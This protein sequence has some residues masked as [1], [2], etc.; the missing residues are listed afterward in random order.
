M[1]GKTSRPHRQR[2]PIAIERTDLSH[3]GRTL[4]ERNGTLIARAVYGGDSEGFWRL[5]SFQR[6]GDFHLAG[7]LDLYA[8]LAADFCSHDPEPDFVAVGGFPGCLQDL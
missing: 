5:F 7:W 3:G 1:G 8:P 6:E 4:P 2:L